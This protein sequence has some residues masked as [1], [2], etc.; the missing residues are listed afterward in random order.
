MRKELGRRD[1]PKADEETGRCES[2]HLREG[3]HD[4]FAIKF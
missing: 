3:R 4:H 1:T 2:A